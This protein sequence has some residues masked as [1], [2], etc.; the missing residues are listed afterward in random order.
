MRKAVLHLKKSDPVLR[1]L[2]ERVGP[3]RIEH[4]DPTFD[5]LVRSIVYQQLSGKVAAVIF[6]RLLA[7]VKGELTPRRVLRLPHERMRALGLSNQKAT[8]I[9]DLAERTKSGEVDFAALPGMS[10]EQV[11]ETLTRVKGI[12][13]WTAQMFLIF[14]LKRMDVLPVGDLGVRAAIKKAYGLEELPK[15]VDME[16]LARAWR[17]YCSVASWYL[18]R[19]LDGPAAL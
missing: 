11:I 9:R 4:R 5:M 2:V 10:D 12:G 17:P 15:P 16:E 13:V 18:W 7:A 19:S 1:A 6:G 14:A 8:Y 3:C